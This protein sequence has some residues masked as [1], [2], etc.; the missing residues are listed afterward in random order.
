MTWV[1]HDGGLARSSLPDG[2]CMDIW[3]YV[4]SFQEIEGPQ[5]GTDR[6]L[7]SSYFCPDLKKNWT[8]EVGF[9]VEFGDFLRNIE[10]L[11]YIFL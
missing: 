6:F 8:F 1:D 9:D 11:E 7:M 3:P 10:D 2:T 4:V 5:G